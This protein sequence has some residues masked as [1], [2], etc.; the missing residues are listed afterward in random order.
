MATKQRLYIAFAKS[1]LWVEKYKWKKTC[2]NRFYNTLE[3]FYGKKNGS[4]KQLYF[5]SIDPGDWEK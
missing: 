4:R 2:K 1:S 3:L 5:E